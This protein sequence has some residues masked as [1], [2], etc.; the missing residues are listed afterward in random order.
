MDNERRIDTGDL[1]KRRL[2]L[3]AT[4]RIARTGLERLQDDR[5]SPDQATVTELPMTPE[6][7]SRNHH[8]TAR[9]ESNQPKLS[10][11]QMI[12]KLEAEGVIPTAPRSIENPDQ[13]I[14]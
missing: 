6:Q 5:V 7:K 11:Q 10:A 8:P 4:L 1:Y 13:V 9:T 14:D 3:R 2:S 12:A